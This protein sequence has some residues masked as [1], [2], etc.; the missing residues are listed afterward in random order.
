MT[1]SSIRK[2]GKRNEEN[3]TKAYL[4]LAAVLL[5]TVNP[6]KEGYAERLAWVSSDLCHA[7][8]DALDADYDDYRRVAVPEEYSQGFP[9]VQLEFNFS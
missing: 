1:K 9:G 3:I 6:R 5:K 4:G 2:D 7:I 8:C